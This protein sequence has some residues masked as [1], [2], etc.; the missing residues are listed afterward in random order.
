MLHL[1]CGAKWVH[2]PNYWGTLRY[3]AGGATYQV[4]V[5]GCENLLTV[6]WPDKINL[7]ALDIHE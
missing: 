5:I 6:A 7:V 4:C 2:G 3:V 1:R